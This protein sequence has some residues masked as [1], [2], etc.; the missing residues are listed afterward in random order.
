MIKDLFLDVR[1]PKELGKALVLKGFNVTVKPLS[2][3]TCHCKVMYP[4]GLAECPSCHTAREEDMKT[5]R[6][7]DIC[8]SKYEFGI[9][10]KRGNDYVTSTTSSK[11]YRQIRDLATIFGANSALVLEDYG[12][13]SGILSENPSVA[14]WL[15]SIRGEC[16]RIG[17]KFEQVQDS[18]EL[19]DM[20]YWICN[21][22]GEP[23]KNR[24][25]IT[26]RTEEIP[27][28]RAQ[29][30]CPMTGPDKSKML[31]FFF[32][33]LKTIANLTKAELRILPGFGE[34]TADTVWKFYNEK[35]D[36]EWSPKKKQ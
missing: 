35:V 24:H 6:V 16:W 34:K 32:K 26:N 21:K 27:Q 31:L 7:A 12:Y 29:E 11:T 23:D 20:I 2:F 14:S 15:S 36:V 22:L 10:I 1:E 9:E 4:L 13:L 8:G 28:L 33:N 5:D 17:I 3:V 30:E 19:A 25:E 18:D